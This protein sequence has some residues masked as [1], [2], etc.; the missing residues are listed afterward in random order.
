MRGSVERV[1]VVNYPTVFPLLEHHLLPESFGLDVLH[2]LATTVQPSPGWIVQGVDQRGLLPRLRQLHVGDLELTRLILLAL[3]LDRPD[4]ARELPA[5][6]TVRADPVA[7]LGR[8][9]GY[10]S[11]PETH[12]ELF[13]DRLELGLQVTGR[14][15]SRTG[16]RWRCSSGGRTGL[17]H[18]RVIAQRAALDLLATAT[19][20]CR[21]TECEHPGHDNKPA[22]TCALHLATP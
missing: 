22:K 2:D 1:D 10:E 18:W 6:F 14:L 21:R 19:H 20:E 9:A 4:V 12:I 8:V 3:S 7:K 16:R 15:R 13:G 5:G 17:G 11:L